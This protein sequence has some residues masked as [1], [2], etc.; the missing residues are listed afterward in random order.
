MAG[1]PLAPHSA[2]PL[3][4]R[5]RLEA[6]RA[7]EPFL[8]YRDGSGKQRLFDLGAGKE[9]VTIGRRPERDIALEWD[10]EVSRLHATLERTGGDWTV[11]D[12]RLSRNGSFLNGARLTGRQ[13]LS[14]GDALRV[15]DTVLAFCDPQHGRSTVTVASDGT[16]VLADLSETQRRVLV[17]LCRPFNEGT[18]FATP[19][20]NRQIADEL[21]L[22]V[23][24]IKTHLRGLFRKFEIEH[25][26]QNEKRARL[27]ACAFQAGLVPAGDS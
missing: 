18:G 5:D 14:H 6:E 4:L 21:H 3:E 23:D 26:P 2:S 8:V 16:P 1:S 15:G 11:A 12:D 20:T 13:R 24:A 7:G 10:L 19:A 25:L 27:V 22:S 9:R 17:A